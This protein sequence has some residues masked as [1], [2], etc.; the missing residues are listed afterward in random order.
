MEKGIKAA[1]IVDQVRDYIAEW[2][3][4][5]LVG[6]IFSITQVTLSTDMRLATAWVEVY[7]E[8]DQQ[9][10]LNFL[11]KNQGKYQ[12][13]LNSKAGKLAMLKVQFQA[14]ESEKFQKQFDNLLMS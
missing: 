7:D 2:T 12:R 1:R 13:Q 5:D 4:E 14:D 3:H 6:Y 10:V 11:K 8:K 9:K